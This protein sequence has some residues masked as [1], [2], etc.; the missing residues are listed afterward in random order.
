[1]ERGAEVRERFHETDGVTTAFQHVR[2]AAIIVGVRPRRAEHCIRLAPQMNNRYA[3]IVSS[4]HA[5]NESDGL[6]L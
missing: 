1:V 2:G 3:L 6:D 5:Y 4:G